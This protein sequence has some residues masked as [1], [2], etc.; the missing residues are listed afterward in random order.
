MMMKIQW[1]TFFAC[2]IPCFLFPQE[3]IIPKH[4]FI[5]HRLGHELIR[6]SVYEYGNHNG[7]V[8]INLHSDE[9]ASVDAAVNILERKGGLLIKIENGN[10]RNITFR[11]DNGV[12]AFDPNRIFSRVGIQHTLGRFKNTSEEAIETVEAFASRI[13]SLIPDEPACVIALHNNTEGGLA[14]NSYLPGARYE[15]DAKEVYVN[16]GE[17]PDDFFLTTDSLLFDVL[18][19]A[20]FNIVLQDNERVEQDGSLS[21]YCGE[22]NI[23]YLN[24]ETQ[25]GKVKQHRKMLERA[26]QFIV[27]KDVNTG[28]D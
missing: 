28:E 27:K 1:L 2:C 11:L 10:K 7:I 19:K 17:D 25:H 14:I 23:R 18:A 6:I 22:R 20:R 13:I 9:T 12:Y 3:K 15:K 26:L 16:P 4:R 5:D 24:C 21:V 8:Y